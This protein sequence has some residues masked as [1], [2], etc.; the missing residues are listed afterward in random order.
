MMVPLLLTSGPVR[1]EA[2]LVVGQAWWREGYWLVTVRTS[3]CPILIMQSARLGRDKYQF[4]SHW[5]DWTRIRKCVVQIRTHDLRI[6]WSPRTGGICSTHMANKHVNV[7]W[8]FHVPECKC[9]CSKLNRSMD[10]SVRMWM[11]MAC[12]IPRIWNLSLTVYQVT[13]VTNVSTTYKFSKHSNIGVTVLT[14]IL[15]NRQLHSRSQRANIR[16]VV[17]IST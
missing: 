15:I 2:V 14:H 16:S 12:H 6:P 3:L 17:Q 13:E 10:R 4:Y 11:R 5:F 1:Y 8:C 7:E 9:E